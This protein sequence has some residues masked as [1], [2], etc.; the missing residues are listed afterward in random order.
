MTKGRDM[1]T[2][3]QRKQPAI[4]V[5]VAVLGILESRARTGRQEGR[6][7]DRNGD[8]QTDS[9]T[10]R[11]VPSSPPVNIKFPCL[12]KSPVEERRGEEKGGFS[13]SSPLQ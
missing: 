5:T 6:E 12:T 11:T 13:L 3:V 9:A 8:R 7:T 1:L 10:H 2:A 4:L